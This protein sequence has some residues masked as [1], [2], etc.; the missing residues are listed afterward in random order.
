MSTESSH[1]TDLRNQENDALI[2][3]FLSVLDASKTE[4]ERIEKIWILING[5]IRGARKTIESPGE[6]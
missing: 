5:V 6:A 3:Q 1:L 4:E 2:R